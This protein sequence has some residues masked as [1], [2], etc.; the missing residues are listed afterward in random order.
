MQDKTHHPADRFI[1]GFD[2]ALR[3]LFGRPQVTERPDPADKHPEADMSEQER[4]ITAR[5]M[6]INH[7][8][9]VCAQALYQ[10]QAL[11]AKLPEVRD[12]MERAAQEE[13]DHLDWCESRL[14]ALDNRKSLL[15]PFWYAGSFMIGAAAGL[16]GDKWSLGFVAETEHQVEAHL[17]DHLQKLPAQDTKSRVVLEQMKEDEIHHATVA[18]E[19]GGA[20]L[21]SPIKL[22]MKLT[23]KLMT[24]SVYYL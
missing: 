22:A 8:G 2:Q 1:I 4:D 17:E 15:N 18:L 7:T 14:K 5:L 9:E 20:E 12:S 3:T 21:P 10:G 23:S 16:A 19:A 6:R 11:T 13:N 24:K